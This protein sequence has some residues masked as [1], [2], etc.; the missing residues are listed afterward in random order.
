[1]S[2]L[3]PT[4]S[5]TVTNANGLGVRAE[6][7]TLG[8]RIAHRLVA[9]DKQGNSATLLETVEDDLQTD[10][11]DSPVFQELHLETLPD[12]SG[13]QAA[14]LV[15]KAGDGHWSLVVR[16]EESESRVGIVLEAAC[17]VKSVPANLGS[18]YTLGKGIEST[19]NEMSTNLKS[20]LGEFGLEVL[21]VGQDTCS[22]CQLSL[23]DHRLEINTG[24]LEID[25]L[26]T[27]I[28]WRYG[29]WAW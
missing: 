24:E 16:P 5:I 29:I 13:R 22:T 4:A 6:F 1:M 14:M 3:E 7:L 11:P 21:P 20:R 27:T 8:D 10:W 28:Q 12:D 15:G 26:P 2:N 9:C 17:R 18:A 23:Q 25:R 19:A